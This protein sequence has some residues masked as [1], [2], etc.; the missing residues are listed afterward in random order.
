MGGLV[1]AALGAYDAE[2]TNR[3][4]SGYDVRGSR[5]M[6]RQCAMPSLAHPALGT[7]CAVVL[8]ALAAAHVLVRCADQGWS[9]VPVARR[10][11][12]RTY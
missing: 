2:Q 12:L 3:S 6:R 10:H 9:S 1:C 5:Q 7:S 4:S 11:C 8:G